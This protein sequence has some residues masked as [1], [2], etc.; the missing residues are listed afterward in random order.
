M[1]V[2]YVLAAAAAGIFAW[3]LFD[4]AALIAADDGSGCDCG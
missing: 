2:L 1:N 4:G 3:E